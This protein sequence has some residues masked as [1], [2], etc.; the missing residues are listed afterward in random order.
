MALSKDFLVKG[1]FKFE[2]SDGSTITNQ[3]ATLTIDNCYITVSSISGD[4][5]LVKI[6]IL[7]RGTDVSVIRYYQFQPSV[8]DGSVNFIKQAYEYLKTLPEFAD[9]TDC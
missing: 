9:A 1:Y 8:E 4:K 2:H 6:S 5:E 7:C 3:D